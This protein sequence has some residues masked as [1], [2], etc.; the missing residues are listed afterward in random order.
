M[1]HFCKIGNCARHK[2]IRDFI[3]FYSNRGSLESKQT[4]STRKVYVTALIK[5]PAKK[6]KNTLD[7][8]RAIKTFL[9]EHMDKPSDKMLRLL[10]EKIW[11]K[12]ACA[13]EGKYVLN[14][15]LELRNKV[16]RTVLA[17]A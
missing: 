7:L 8:T 6:E 5:I 17:N 2:Q 11:N 9:K 15:N 14:E 13:E 1:P 3:F 12:Y 10:Q 4:A 16:A